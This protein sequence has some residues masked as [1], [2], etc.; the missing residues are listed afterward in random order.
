MGFG[1]FGKLTR[2]IKIDNTAWS[3]FTKRI[4]EGKIKIGRPPPL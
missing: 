3:D 4:R 2:E 1:A